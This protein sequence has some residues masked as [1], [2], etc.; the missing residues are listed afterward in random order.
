MEDP[1]INITEIRSFY[2]GTLEVFAFL[3]K[4]TRVITQLKFS[5]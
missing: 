2:Q 4:N 5:L 3:Q 1:Y